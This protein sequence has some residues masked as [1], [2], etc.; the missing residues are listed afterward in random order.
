MRPL[1]EVIGVPSTSATPALSGSCPSSTLSNDVFPLPLGPSTAM[2]SPRRH[3]QVEVVPQH[4]VAERQP[5]A[6]QRHGMGMAVDGPD[7]FDTHGRAYRLDR[8]AASSWLTVLRCQ[9]R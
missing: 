4:P 8:S 9:V 7:R 2:N 3:R 6:A 5:G 1:P